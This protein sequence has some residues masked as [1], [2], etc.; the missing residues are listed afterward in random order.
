MLSHGERAEREREN[1]LLITQ[2]SLLMTQK[3][4]NY[5]INNNLLLVIIGIVK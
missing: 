1:I 3:T 5:S 2:L 4:T